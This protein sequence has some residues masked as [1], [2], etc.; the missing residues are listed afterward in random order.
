MYDMLRIAALEYQIRNGKLSK[1]N[2]IEGVTMQVPNILDRAV[3]A[4]RALVAKHTPKA[5]QPLTM[6]QS[7]AIAK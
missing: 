1:V 2:E 5:S 6:R 7:G 3:V 4:L